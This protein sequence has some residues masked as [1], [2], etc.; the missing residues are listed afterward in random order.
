[1]G[2][3]TDMCRGHLYMA[4]SDPA[5]LCKHRVLLVSGMAGGLVGAQLQGRTSGQDNESVGRSTGG[6]CSRS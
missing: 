1:M 6:Y 4:T 5:G 3:L 2:A